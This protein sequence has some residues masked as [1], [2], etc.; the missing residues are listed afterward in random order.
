MPI[1]GGWAGWMKEEQQEA[2]E[3]GRLHHTRV[4]AFGEHIDARM[5]MH[6][7]TTR[8]VQKMASV[9]DDVQGDTKPACS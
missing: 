1:T 8:A 2:E 3:V 6:T 9:S 7:T 5:H 4:H